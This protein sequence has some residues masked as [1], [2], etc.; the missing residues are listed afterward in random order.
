MDTKRAIKDFLTTRRARISPQHVGLPAGGRR[1]VPG[2]RREEVALLAGVSAEY[3]VQIERGHVAG[4]STEV[5]GA[6]ARALELD[7]V[8]TAHLGDLVRAATTRR[9]RRQARARPPQVP[10]YLD[11]LMSALVGAPA[12]VQNGR[13]DVIGTNDLGR[14]LYAPV[15]DSG[16]PPNTARFLFLDERAAEMFPQWDRAADD[17]VALLQVEAARSP[18]SP[19]ITELVG[20]LATR[21]EE[22]RARWARHDVRAHHRGTKRFRHPVVGELDLRFEGLAVAG[23][24]GLTL[25]GYTAEPATTSA[26]NLRLLASWVGA[27]EPGPDPDP[28]LTGR[29]APDSGT[30]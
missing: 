8:E 18:D 21:S 27:G 25:I 13:L 24:P 11:A 2:L 7:D 22:F 30:G 17:A 29:V 3:Y 14:A 20:S 23:S 5:L 26:E 16:S 15:L 6:V 12:I 19:G 28:A 10:E 1:R 9:P 4:V